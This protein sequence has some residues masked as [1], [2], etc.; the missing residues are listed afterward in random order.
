[1]DT[2]LSAEQR[3]YLETI[4]SSARALLGIVNDIL[5]F[6][7]MEKGRLEIV[8]EPFELHAL[9]EESFP[10]VAVEAER[11]GLRV[12]LEFDPSIPQR[13]L[14]D[15]MRL[16]QVLLNLLSNAVKF[17]HTGFV[18]LEAR[19]A[20]PGLVRFEVCDSGIGIPEEKQREIFKAFTQAD[21]SI[22]RRYGGAGL[23][24]TIS[25]ELVRRMGGRL[26][27]ES[28]PGQGSRFFFTL[29]LPPDEPPAGMP[30]GPAPA[31]AQADEKRLRILLAEDNPVNRLAVERL[32][33]RIGH[34]VRSVADGAAAVREA[35]RCEWDLILM[36]VQMPQM[37][38]LEATRRI[39]EHEAR[40][41]A[42]RT[43]V[44]GLTAH[45]FAEDVQRCLDAGMDACL[46]KPFH[47]DDLKRLMGEPAARSGQ[48]A[49]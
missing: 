46:V 10:V 11:K 36:D 49:G 37:E 7:R 13:V 23:G 24:L 34:E 15:G 6:S 16:R 35:L 39:R 44:V 19:A 12:E 14:G 8:R 45:A 43:R 18:R 42:G 4:R 2:P 31:P 33:Q 1:L 28:K 38:G 17:T 25:E 9:L 40:R 30:A 20:G 47:L 41:G 48:S 22:T 27:L 5:D 29:P 21:S 32:L 3:S 26:E